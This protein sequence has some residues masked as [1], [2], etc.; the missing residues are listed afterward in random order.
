[1]KQHQMVEQGHFALTKNIVAHE[2]FYCG[3]FAVIKNQAG[4]NSYKII[5]NEWPGKTNPIGRQ[6]KTGRRGETYA[7]KDQKA[8]VATRPIKNYG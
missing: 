3:E 1:M 7:H 6:A 8:K 5:I 4:L 2:I